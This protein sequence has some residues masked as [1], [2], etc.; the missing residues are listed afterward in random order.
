MLKIII[1]LSI[2]F[3]ALFASAQDRDLLLQKNLVLT[4]DQ[5]D[6]VL[7][8]TESN[9]RVF[10]ENFDVKLDSSTKITSQKLIAGTL[11]QPVLKISVRKCVFLFCQNIDLDAEFN[12]VKTK[13]TCT[14]NYQLNADLERSSALLADLYS[15]ISTD[16]CIQ[17]TATGAQASLKVNVLHANSYQ[18]GVVQKL[19]FGFIKL[20]AD[21]IVESFTRV[22]KLNGIKD[23]R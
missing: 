15:Q 19:T 18:T 4:S 16:I 7:A 9:I 12:L 20:Q 17:K 5:I 2:G 22:M 6:N 8:K 3:G 10:V 11:I 14:F 23:I 13:G 21:G 1:C